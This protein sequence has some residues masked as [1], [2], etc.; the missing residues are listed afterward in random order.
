MHRRNLLLLSL[1]VLASVATRWTLAAELSADEK[2]KIEKLIEHVGGLK[3]A[4]FVRN[5]VEYDAASAAK[6]LQAKWEANAAEIASARQFI[7]QVATKSSTSG[8]PYLIRFKSGDAIQ[9]VAS[10]KYL[11]EQLQRIEYK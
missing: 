4:K 5:D 10:G 1:V 11:L 2:A 7:E 9:D 3:D 8:K 6:F